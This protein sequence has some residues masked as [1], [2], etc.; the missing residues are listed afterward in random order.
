MLI[1]SLEPGLAVVV[2]TPAECRHLALACEQDPGPA[3]PVA[4]AW[5]TAARPAFSALG[6]AA[7]A[8]GNLRPT[9]LAYY[10]Q[11]LQALDAE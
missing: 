10:R 8:L 7:L 11:D 5:L 6:A 9:D 4:A 3:H 1:Q 2:L